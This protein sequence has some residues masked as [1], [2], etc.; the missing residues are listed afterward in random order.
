MNSATC[1]TNIQMILCLTVV[2]ESNSFPKMMVLIEW[3][4]LV[5]THNM[6]VERGFSVMKSSKSLNESRMRSLLNDSV[7]FVRDRFDRSNFECF[8]QSER[9]LER[10]RKAG[11]EYKKESN[12]LVCCRIER[13]SQTRSLQESLGDFKRHTLKELKRNIQAVEKELNETRQCVEHL[14]EKKRRLHLEQSSGSTRYNRISETIIDSM[15]SNRLIFSFY[16]CRLDQLMLLSSFET[17][18]QVKLIALL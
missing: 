3:F 14:E 17:K 4:L 11:A 18:F 10:I 6:V 7:R 5:V 1:N 16:S 9:L 2:D 13:A 8:V 12:Q 15:F